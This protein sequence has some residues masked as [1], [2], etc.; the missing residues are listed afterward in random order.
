MCDD[1]ERLIGYVYDECDASERRLIDAHLAE[2]ATCRDEI[3]G[4]R[5]VREDLL[6]WEIPE[7]QSVWRPVAPPQTTVWW[8]QVPV[9]AMAAAATVMFAIGSAGGILTNAIL[10][11]RA[12]QVAMAA[13]NQTPTPVTTAVAPDLSEQQQQL[14]A[15][16]REDLGKMVDQRFRASNQAGARDLVRATNIS[17]QGFGDLNDKYVSLQDYMSQFS[18]NASNDLGGLTKRVMDLESQIQFLMAQ[19]R[20]QA[21]K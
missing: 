2:C 8:R 17:N 18:K 19:Q 6:A 14:V 20:L 4:L 3:S 12:A 13:Q 10:S 1:R 5:A 15:S 9:W 16:L 7:H 11:H 21:A